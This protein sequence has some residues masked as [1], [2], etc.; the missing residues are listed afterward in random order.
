MD[1]F[2]MY[3]QI[4]GMVGQG[5]SVSAI[6]RKLK[7]SRNTVYKYLEKSPDEMAEWTASTMIRTKKLDIHKELILNWLREYPDI[8]TG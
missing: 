1:K 5:Y 2:E 8:S 6:S 7:I 3:I 4:R